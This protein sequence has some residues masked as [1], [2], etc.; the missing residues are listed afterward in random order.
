MLRVLVDVRVDNSG[1]ERL[2][3]LP[4]TEVVLIDSP[5]ESVRRPLP[6]ALLQDADVLACSLPPAN[7]HE[8][9]QLRLVQIA[10]V[11]Y[12]Q[13]V[14]L[15]LAQRGVR[16]A[17][18]RGVFDVPISEWNVA[19]M[20][21]LLRDLRG[22]LRNQERG[23][24]DRDSRHQRE[25][26]GLTVGLWGYGGI[27]RETARLA[28]A[29]GMR[30]HVLVRS[31][32]GGRDDTYRVPHSGD[33]QGVLPDRVFGTDQRMEFLGGLDFLIL[34]MPLSAA[35]EG[36]VGAAELQALPRTACLLNPA[37]GPLVREDALLAALREGWI[38]GAALDTHYRY[39]LNADHPL[40]GLPNVILTPHI[41]GSS[42]STHFLRR[43][44]EI[45]V[46]N[47][48]RLRTGRPL[49]NELTPTELAG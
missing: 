24:W 10:S 8:A 18:A 11:G 31:G 37:R 6:T 29:L 4:G 30:V 47:V 48:D 26:R 22:M 14:G 19:M 25:L 42:G 34:A 38:A 21:N 45:L 15:G 46:E 49:L 35:N 12:T 13:L 28:K 27:G 33:P 39:P 3:S 1:L 16:A 41:S 20:V 9:S 23:V 7:L 36:V 5:E 2:R 17:N 44:W 40:W 43:I 32:V